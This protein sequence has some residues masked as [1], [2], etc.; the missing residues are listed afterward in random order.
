[1]P[2]VNPSLY[3]RLKEAQLVI[4]KGDLNY[5][6][7]L[8]DFSWDSTESFETCLRGESILTVI[9]PVLTRFISLLRLSSFNLCTLRT[10]KADLIC[11]LGAGVADQLFAK[12]KE[13][14]LTG[15][16]GVIQ[17]ASK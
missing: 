9:L 5:R 12:D 7:L 15:E 14:M 2:E 8:G 6:K 16:Y 13:W 3:D 4:F 10:I 17:F 11:G 1:M